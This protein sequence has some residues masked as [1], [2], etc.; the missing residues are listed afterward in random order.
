MTESLETELY[1]SSEKDE[2]FEKSPWPK[3]FTFNAEVVKVFDNMV[4]RSVPL[5]RE[6]VAGAVHWTRAYYQPKTRIIDVGCSTGTF[7]ELLGRFLKQPAILVGIDNSQDMLDKAKEKLAQ[8]QDL[9]QIEL[10]CENAENYS[11]ENSSV[12]VMN[13]T[14]QFLS[15][16][17]RQ[18]LLQAIYQGLVPGGLL[19][20]SEKIRSSCPQ[21]QE[22][23]ARHY[24][25]FKA[26]NGYAQ[27]EIERKKEALENVL[28]PLT[29]IQ[30]LQ[31]LNDSGF[32]QVESLIKFHNFISFVALK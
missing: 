26:K 27:N 18:K 12:V 23:I 13:Y 14:L 15:L 20:I 2:L 25:A 7:L 24:E 4:S 19:F 11:F 31:M 21:F 30:Q 32:Q 6:V 5:Y 9:H 10:I 29:E 3:P 16:P 17:Q 22:Q 8:I 28:V 1:L